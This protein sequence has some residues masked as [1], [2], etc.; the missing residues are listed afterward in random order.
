MA[1]FVMKHKKTLLILS[2]VLAVFL[3]LF[4]FAGAAKADDGDGDT[5]D[6]AQYI[7]LLAGPV[8]YAAVMKKY[9]GSGK[10][11]KH[12][13]ETEHHV[14]NMAVYDNFVKEV[15]RSTVSSLGSVTYSNEAK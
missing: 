6:G 10:R 3:V 1:T 7:G 9:S 8:F 11:H 5:E 14:S 4:V 15:K 13:R 12:E 2:I